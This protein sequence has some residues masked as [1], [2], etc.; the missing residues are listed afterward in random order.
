MQKSD[1]SGLRGRRAGQCFRGPRSA[2][3]ALTVAA[4]LSGAPNLFSQIA[5]L[6]VQVVEGD[7]AVHATG[8][9]ASRPIV[10]QVTDETGSPV[11]GATVS[12]RLPDEGPTGVFS[13][14]IRTDLVATD[15]HGRAAL[16]SLQFGRT[17][18]QLQIR[19]TAAKGEAR[20]GTLST[21][22]LGGKGL[23]AASTPA[24]ASVATRAAAAPISANSAPAAPS[25]WTP[26]SAPSGFARTGAGNSH[27][28]LWIV[29]SL[30]AASGAGAALAFRGRGPSAASAAS[31]SGS[32]PPN[33]GPPTIT[34]GHP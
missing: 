7:G 11:E 28:K 19:I 33:I 17:P 15:S 27:R 18:G 25:G 26:N 14:G 20:A 2:L 16:R 32:L 10:V 21:Q 5:I 4:L 24:P 23:S 12:F 34:I 8:S 6:Q 22:I 29:I 13:S 9:K 3:T 30:A 1:P 31:T